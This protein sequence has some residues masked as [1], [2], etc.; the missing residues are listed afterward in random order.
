MREPKRNSRG[1]RLLARLAGKIEAI[2][3]NR[4]LTD[5]GRL[6]GIR[7]AVAEYKRDTRGG[8]TAS[9]QTSS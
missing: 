4:P 6:E 9:G 5:A 3:R 7:E 1:E 8:K 2:V